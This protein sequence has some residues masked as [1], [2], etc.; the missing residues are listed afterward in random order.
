M[1]CDEN[2]ETRVKKKIKSLLLFGKCFFFKKCKSEHTKKNISSC[3]FSKKKRLFF[4]LV[5]IWVGLY[6]FFVVRLMKKKWRYGC[7]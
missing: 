3:K 4:S 1:S 7:R 5:D 6:R 2:V